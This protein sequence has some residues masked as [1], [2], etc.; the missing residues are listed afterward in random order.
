MNIQ[1]PEEGSQQNQPLQLELFRKTPP[2]AA[3]GKP[4]TPI[5]FCCW[6]LFPCRPLASSSEGKALIPFYAFPL[7]TLYWQGLSIKCHQGETPITEDCQRRV[8][9][10]CGL[11]KDDEQ[12]SQVWIPWH[13]GNMGLSYPPWFICC[14]GKPTQ[15]F[16]GAKPH[17]V[18]G[19]GWFGAAK[20]D[21]SASQ[22]SPFQI[23]E[24][25]DYVSY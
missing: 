21:Y 17:Q 8:L 9:I 10:D 14:C 24:I 23:L 12:Q 5:S 13:E 3:T 2:P 15:A 20:P 11:I 22:G 16:K 19:S 4:N 6:R 7:I 1:A 25:S 18:V